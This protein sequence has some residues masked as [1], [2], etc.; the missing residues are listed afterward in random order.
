MTFS[1]G[2]PAATPAASTGFTLGAPPAKAPAAGSNLTFGGAASATQ[3]AAATSAPAFGGF[4]AATTSAPPTAAVA[5]TFGGFGAA[6][7]A[8]TTQTQGF[9]GFGATTAATTSAP[10]FGGFG[11]STATTSAA[12]APAFGGFGGATTAT[13][14]AAPTFGGFGATTATSAAPVAGFGGAAA[15]SLGGFGASTTSTTTT[16]SGLGGN[17]TGGGIL[18]ASSGPQTVTEEN[19]SD[20]TAGKETPIP[21]ELS[22]VVESLKSFIKEEKSLSSEVSHT[23]NKQIKQIKD[24]T[25]ALSQMVIGLKS[26]LQ[27]NRLKL[28]Q[29]KQTCGQ[30]LVNVD[31]CVKTRDTPASMQYDNVAPLEYFYRLVAQFEQSMLEYRQAIQTA[32][33][34]LQAMTQGTT[35]LSPGDIVSAVQR[36][37]QAM[38]HLAAKYQVLHT[39]I[40]EYK[41]QFRVQSRNSSIPPVTLK[42]PSPFQAPVD[43]LTRARQSLT[44]HGPPVQS[45]L[46]N[47]PM[48]PL[49]QQ[50]SAFNQFGAAPAFN[51]SGFGN[52][53]GFGGSSFGGVNSSFGANSNSSSVTIGN[54]RNKC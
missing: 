1:F 25:E 13:S 33:T 18:G 52:N 37:H 7:T 31:I 34:H 15:P 11:T 35:G 30:E 50:Q 26:T 2:A 19:K 10:A 24:D 54:K 36:L 46:T 20:G 29:L 40:N 32:E 17:T 48:Q 21:A 5:P 16:I 39:T 47:P 53:T 3:A 43:P 38:T 4:G 6:S 9:G 42:G 51:S 12:P 49:G 23:T 27:N 41:C 8:A 22:A 14:T 45:L 28:D 44:S